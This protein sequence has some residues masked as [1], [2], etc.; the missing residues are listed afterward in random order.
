MSSTEGQYTVVGLIMSDDPPCR[1]ADH[2]LAVSPEDAEDTAYRLHE[3]C[4][5]GFIV[6]GVFEGWL[7]AVDEQ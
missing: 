5:D 6:A 3:D 7:N 4:G 2:V 1:I